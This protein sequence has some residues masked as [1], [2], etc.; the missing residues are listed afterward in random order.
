MSFF[1]AGWL[2]FAAGLTA[3]G[4]LAARGSFDRAL[5]PLTVTSFLWSLLLGIVG[6]Q[7]FTATVQIQVTLSA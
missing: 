2:L 4:L 6:F 3:L 7:A 1:P 5:T